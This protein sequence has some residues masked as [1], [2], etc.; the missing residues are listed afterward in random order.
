M[1]IQGALANVSQAVDLDEFLLFLAEEL[2]DGSFFKFQPEPGRIYKAAIEWRAIIAD[3]AA[4]ITIANGLWQAYDRF[5]K[6]INQNKSS[7]GAAI[8]VMLKSDSGEFEQ[9]MIG[10]EIKD[11]STFVASFQESVAKLNIDLASQ[12]PGTE[13]EEILYSGDWIQVK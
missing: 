12:V 11:K 10:S 8:F 3:T 5:V 9:F 13:L 2:P 1:F 4:V 6:P 7:S